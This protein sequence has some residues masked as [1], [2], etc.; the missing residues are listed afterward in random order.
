MN[1]LKQAQNSL[2]SYLFKPKYIKSFLSKSKISSEDLFNVFNN[3]MFW[4]I[5]LLAHVFEDLDF[6]SD[7]LIFMSLSII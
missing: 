2:I 4:P 7:K 5:K 3:L 1:L 6:R